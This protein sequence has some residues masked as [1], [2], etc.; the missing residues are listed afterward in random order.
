MYLNIDGSI[1]INPCTFTVQISLSPPFSVQRGCCCCCCWL[2]LPKEQ[3]FC[4]RRKR[5]ASLTDSKEDL[6]LAAT[7]LQ[8]GKEKRM[9][10]PWTKS[11]F[12]TSTNTFVRTA[13][14]QIER[15]RDNFRIYVRACVHVAGIYCCLLGL[16]TYVR[17]YVPCT[18]TTH[19]KWFMHMALLQF[20]C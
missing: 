9:E 11:C 12:C 8:G 19:V 2:K 16:H 4:R 6:G 1:G 10:Y 13:V 14:R 7:C 20:C 3:R 18:T 17:M 15:E 5:W